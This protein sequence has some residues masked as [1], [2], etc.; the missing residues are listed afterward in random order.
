MLDR[1]SF[2]SRAKARSKAS[3]FFQFEKSG[4]RYL[5]SPV[6][7]Q[8]NDGERPSHFFNV[9]QLILHFQFHLICLLKQAALHFKPFASKLKHGER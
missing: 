9:A 5:H 6:A 3:W 2:F 4:M 8:R 7:P 1:K